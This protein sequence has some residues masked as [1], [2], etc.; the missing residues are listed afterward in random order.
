[1]SHDCDH[2]IESV[3]MLHGRLGGDGCGVLLRKT[4]EKWA[5]GGSI[6]ILFRGYLRLLL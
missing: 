6:E 5:G 1:M 2:F 3:V 4:R